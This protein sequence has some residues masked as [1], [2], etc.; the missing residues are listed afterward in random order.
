MKIKVALADDHPAV[1]AGLLHVLEHTADIDVVGTAR[2]STEVVS[3]LSVSLCDV[4]VTDYVMPG[5]RY[6]D[7]L[8]FI[9]FLRRR[10]PGLTLIVFTMLDNAAITRSLKRLGV[11]SILSKEDRMDD[12]LAAVHGR[13]TVEPIWPASSAMSSAERNSADSA[14]HPEALL[15]TLSKR[16]LEVLRLFVSGESVGKIATQLHRTRQ[17]VSAQRIAAMRKLG[18]ARDAD[19]FRFAFENGLIDSG[20]PIVA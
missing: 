4:L 19:L 14:G 6:G 7:G 16:E 12:L 10:F 17:T 11:A 2:N 15:S 5:G 20:H 8:P 18:I 13:K 9:A 1:L 3:L